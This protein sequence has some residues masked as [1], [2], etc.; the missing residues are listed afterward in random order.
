MWLIVGLG[1]PGRKFKF[2]RHNIGFRV[3]DQLSKELSIPLDK[4]RMMALWGKGSW[5]EQ[6]VILAK[7]QTFMNLSGE[8]VVRF[9][10]FFRIET[11]KVIII[12]DDLD[13][14]FGQMKIRNKGGDAGNK[15]LKSIIQSLGESEFIRVRLGISRP[16]K[17]GEGRNY[18]L[19]DFDEQE[20][21]KLN[22]LINQATEAVKTIM[23]ESTAQAMNR[24]NQ[25]V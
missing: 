5:E 23:L 15:G 4:K 2:T 13:L 17:K 12:H 16:E 7:P 20:K 21:K 8:A 3:I 25:K 9:K 1:N 11:D 18:V 19:A 24:F 10:N 14:N 6:K 22:I